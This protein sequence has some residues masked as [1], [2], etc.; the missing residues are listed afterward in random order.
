M[1]IAGFILLMMLSSTSLFAQQSLDGVWQTGVDNT[2]IETYRKD[3]AWFGK[4]ISSDNPRA[5]TGTDILRNFKKNGDL[6]EGQLYAIKKDKLVNAIITPTE[7]KLLIKV[8][9]GF[10]TKN[11]EWLKVP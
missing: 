2:K 3:G 10:F 9:V 6:W 5:K 4:I 8:S 11:L 1:R 7:N